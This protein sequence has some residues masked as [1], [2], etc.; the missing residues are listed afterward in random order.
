MKVLL[1]EGVPRVIQKHLTNFS[2]LTVED[3]GWRGVHNGELLSLM[4]PE[5]QVLVTTDKNISHQQNFAKHGISL[6]VLP[7]NKIPDVVALLNVIE[8]KISGVKAGEVVE[9]ELP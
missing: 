5:F 4:S 2:V 9:I 7:S 8:E 6:I 1:D 3:Q